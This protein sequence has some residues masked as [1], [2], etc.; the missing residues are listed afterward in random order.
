MPWPPPDGD[1]AVGFYAQ[2]SYKEYVGSC[3]TFP[4]PSNPL[5]AGITYTLSFW[6][7]GA[8]VN[9]THSQTLEEGR[10]IGILFPDQLP[11]ALFGY[12]NACVPFPVSV[13]PGV[14]D[15]IGGVP[16][17]NELGR[18]LVQ[19]SGEWVR[20]SITF[21]PTEDIHSIMIGG[22]C[23]VPA[24][25]S[26]RPF[27]DGQG[28]TTWLAPYFMV[29]ELMLTEAQDQVLSPT[30]VTGNLCAQ[31]VIARA[32][33]PA[34]ATNYQWYLDGVALVG[35]TAT[36]L[37][38]SAGGYGP[39]LYTMGMDYN[40][41]CL[42]GSA[43]VAPPTAPTPLPALGPNV[44]CAPL[45]VAFSDTTGGGSQTLLWDLGDGSTSNDS[46]LV[47][48]YSQ[49]GTYDVTLRVRNRAGCVGDTVLPAAVVVFPGV[50]GQI[51][52]TPNPVDLEDPTV[53]L[54]GSGTGNIL[55]WWWDLGNA[56]PSTANSSSVEVVF[57][58]EAG[59]YSV[60]LVVASA[61]GCVDT[62][63]SMIRVVDIGVIEMPNV[64]S[65]NGDGHNDNFTPLNYNGTP[66]LLEVYNRWGQQVFST[67]A[68]AQGWSGGDVPDG[69]YYFLV[70]PDDRKIAPFTGH[71]TLVR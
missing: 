52:A 23:D 8:S 10:A 42:M 39:G 66:G 47:H 28:N 68:L 17:W 62:V 14:N 59:E 4:Q 54:T 48:T 46:S 41:E 64:F 36:T 61:E 22:A 40:G 27:T 55:S 31:D 11:L 3:L 13:P 24:S 33:P 56:I 67:R 65:P 34:G 43:F 53:Q 50:I 35:Q 20:L 15:C 21:T 60:L 2:E 32:W 9:G 37:D 58:A 16:G 70:T 25:F 49:A 57:P 45:I 38:V 26:D 29:D 5:I 12:A 63:R 7:V 1:G 51:S 6:I 19:P 18:V 71:V 69:T 30:T 44:G